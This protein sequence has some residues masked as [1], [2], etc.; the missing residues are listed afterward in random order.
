MLRK[1]LLK[2]AFDQIN[3]LGKMSPVF[4]VSIHIYGDSEEIHGKTYI[5]RVNLCM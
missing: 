3:H 5:L 2:N 4:R 1:S